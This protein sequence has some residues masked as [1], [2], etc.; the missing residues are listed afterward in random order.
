MDTQDLHIFT[1]E[2]KT[3]KTYRIQQDLHVNL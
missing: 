2:M 3:L 1:I